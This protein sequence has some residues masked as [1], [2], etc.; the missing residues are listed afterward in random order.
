MGGFMNNAE[1]L[2]SYKIQH[3]GKVFSTNNCGNVIV[4]EY[5][6]KRNIFVQFLDTGYKTCV[7]L[8]ELLNGNIKDYLIPSVCGVGITGE[9]GSKKDREYMLWVG[10]LERCYSEKRHKNRPTYKSCTTSENFNYYPY[11]K[12]WCNKQIGFGNEG[13]ELD[14]D[15]LVKGNKVYSEDTCC[16][17]PAEINVMFTKTDALRGKHPI[18][19]QYYKPS[20]CFRAY[21]GCYSKRIYLGQFN[22]ELEAFRAYKQAKEAYIKEVA[23]KWKDQIDP[24]V[25]NAL[26]KYEVEITD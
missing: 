26:M 16:F 10:L 20:D 9:K 6:N 5:L 1:K 24:K 2:R 22:T 11:F 18:G 13:W 21:V 17:V 25:Y 15:I 23:N 8:K 12:S 7:E 19:V 14:K 3:E 4:L